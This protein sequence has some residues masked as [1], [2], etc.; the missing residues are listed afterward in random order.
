MITDSTGSKFGDQQLKNNGLSPLKGR[1][2]IHLAVIE[3]AKWSGTASLLRETMM[4][5]FF[6]RFL[7]APVGVV[8][9]L[10][11]LLRPL[12]SECVWCHSSVLDI[13]FFVLFLRR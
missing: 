12:C 9:V 11:L 13:C 3:V 6:S 5:Q 10:Y 8:A 2:G 7:L 4:K 1:G